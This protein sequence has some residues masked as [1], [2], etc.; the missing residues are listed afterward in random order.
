MKFRSPRISI[1]LVAALFLS[2]ITA[3]GSARTGPSVEPA[4]SVRQAALATY[5]HGMTD[6][7]AAGEVGLDGLPHLLD[8][9]SDPEFPRRDNVVAFLAHLHSGAATSA[10]VDFLEDP[11]VEIDLPAED[12]AMLLA[13]LALGQIAKGGDPAALQAL[14]EMTAPAS[15]GGPLARAAAS[16][17]YGESLR[18]DLV[19]AALRGLAL[20]GLADAERRLIEIEAAQTQLVL[21]GTD[22]G[23]A[24]R[25][26][27]ALLRELS[28][29]QSS[30][31]SA[32]SRRSDPSN[33]ET[34]SGDTARAVDN[35][36]S[37]SHD[38]GLTYA[39]H[40]DLASKMTDSVLD[41]LLESASLI[42]ATADFSAD[43]ACC[44]RFSRLGTARS[45]GAGGDGLDVVD[46]DV[47]AG[48]VLSSTV[49]RV[50][51]VRQIN[52]CSGPGTNI[53]GCA[54]VPGNSMMLVRITRDEGVLWAHEYGHNVGLGHVGDD[55]YIMHGGLAPGRNVALFADECQQY[56]FPSPFA[57]PE[58]VDIGSCHD[59]DSDD[60]ASSVDNCPAVNNSDQSD[61]DDDGIGDACDVCP[62]AGD[63]DSDG[64]QVCDSGDNCPAVANADQADAD[65]DGF[66]DACD[67]CPLVS[68]PGQ[69]DSDGDGVG[70]ACS[71]DLDGDG[72]PDVQ[73][74]CIE[75]PNDG[76]A[77]AD[78][79]GSGDPCDNCPQTANAAQQDT[80]NDG[81]GDACDTCT[82]VDGDGFG[83]PG[84][85]TCQLGSVRDC[86]DSAIDTNPRA[87]DLCD[88]V[89]ND[90]DAAID[91]ASCD[92]FDF[93]S[94]GRVDGEE[95]AWLGRS[96]GLCSADPS[97]E[98]WFPAN[99]G[100]NPCIDGDDLAILAGVWGCEESE[101]ICK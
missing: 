9:L 71:G 86:D 14:L 5:V 53:I 76:Q 29:A 84:H 15:Q 36:S 68:N 3:H 17:V 93:T 85:P 79:D 55:R 12:R 42:A 60:I 13:P 46:N 35:S 66:G 44:I 49:A 26:S 83:D 34:E 4:E 72:V 27:L 16:G 77:D 8:L 89:D 91:E 6:E 48:T 47:E 28:H 64:D 33:S 74:N 67:N 97:A 87:A 65:D 21:A 43:V 51:L 81:L 75:V 50:K 1:R 100:G 22:L 80:D 59:D 61:L 54:N 25:E 96:F 19:R 40:V 37:S 24:A 41:A 20:S 56:H 70:D 10:L 90:C 2:V 94:D 63:A 31:G 73:D 30:T 7:I 88:G 38:S 18:D 95:L 11:P 78:D 52:Y 62:G 39:N 23:L 32:A 92:E 99:L 58:I 69:A 98:W 57:S 101:P 82:D 45:F